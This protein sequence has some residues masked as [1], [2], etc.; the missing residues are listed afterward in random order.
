M[1]MPTNLPPQGAVVLGSGSHLVETTVWRG[2]ARGGI[3]KRKTKRPGLDGV[4]GR[5]L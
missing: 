4:S 5:L 3:L 1:K 2:W